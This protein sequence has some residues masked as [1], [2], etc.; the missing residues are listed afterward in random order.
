MGQ[1]VSSSGFAVKRAEM[2]AFSLPFLI[3]GFKSLKE[4][5]D[6]KKA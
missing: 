6:K 4:K 2:L 5:S 1:C 3:K